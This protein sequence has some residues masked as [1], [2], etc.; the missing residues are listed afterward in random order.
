MSSP[1]YA[2]N[3]VVLGLLAAIGPFAID[4]YLPALPTIAADLGATTAATQM[5]LMAFFAGFGITQI[6]YGPLS[7]MLGRKRPLYFGLAL[8]AVCS[9]GCALAPSVEW[10]IGLRFVQGVGAAAVM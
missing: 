8:F 1:R 2:R 3:A 6:V 10:L 4:M 5:T 7:D 9:I